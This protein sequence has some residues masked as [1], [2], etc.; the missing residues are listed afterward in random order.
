MSIQ[1]LFRRWKSLIKIEDIFIW[2]WRWNHYH[3]SYTPMYVIFETFSKLGCPHFFLKWM[4]LQTEVTWA[5]SCEFLHGELWTSVRPASR[6][7]LVSMCCSSVSEPCGFRSFFFK[8]GKL[9]C[10]V[11]F[12]VDFE[13][14]GELHFLNVFF[15]YL[16]IQCKRLALVFDLS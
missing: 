3:K 2:K 7:G 9:A 12:K 16:F 14:S 4:I 15:I 11:N 6:H 10:T 8:L 5:G 13:D 1:F